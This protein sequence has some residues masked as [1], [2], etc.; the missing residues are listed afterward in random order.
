[1][2]PRYRVLSGRNLF[3]LACVA[4]FLLWLVQRVGYY[5]GSQDIFGVLLYA[6]LFSLAEPMSWYNAFVPVGHVLTLGWI[7]INSLERW[8]HLENIAWGGLTLV[9]LSAFHDKA[10]LF[11]V[12]LLLFC[13][14][15]NFLCL[16]TPVMD[17]PALFFVSLAGWVA[18]R[19]WMM[20]DG[21]AKVGA[22]LLM[23]AWLGIAVLFRYHAQVLFFAFLTGVLVIEQDARAKKCLLLLGGFLLGVAPQIFV[24]LASGHVPFSSEVAVN[25]YRTVTDRGLDYFY[26]YPGPGEAPGL[27]YIIKNHFVAL[28]VHEAMGFFHFFVYAL[29]A[30][31]GMVFLVEQHKVRF[32]VLS[33]ICV[34]LL[35]LAAAVGGS[36]KAILVLTVFYVVPLVWLVDVWEEKARLY[37]KKS[38]P[39]KRLRQGMAGLVWLVVLAVFSVPF[40]MNV[41]A[42][43]DVASNVA[44]ITAVTNYLRGMDPSLSPEGIY[45]DSLTLYFPGWP[46]YLPYTASMG[47]L[48]WVWGADHFRPSL[49]K[50]NYGDFLLDARRRGIRYLVLDSYSYLDVEF[51]KNIFLGRMQGEHAPR[52]LASIGSF[53]VF[54]L[55]R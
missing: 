17:A 46:P 43:R 32:C 48:N 8:L 54:Q 31:L 4:L 10:R 14:P 36:E 15:L 55:P 27:A 28:V 19:H 47:W 29:P 23:G 40:G 21:E 24:N 7:P 16:I 12:A 2:W 42:Y 1:M 39:L 33:L 26:H 20:N 41:V 13:I 34:L 50:D 37:V 25:I 35:S 3:A 45:T 44:G 38:F 49:D 52:L 5:L 51:I 18:Y 9:V 30:A 6:K 22:F 53:K 11:R